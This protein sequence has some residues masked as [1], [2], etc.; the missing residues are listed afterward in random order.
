MRPMRDNYALTPDG[1]A[2]R[3]TAAGRVIAGR[4]IEQ[5]VIILDGPELGVERCYDPHNLRL[6]AVSG[7]HEED[8]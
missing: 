6:M 4:C 1:W 3:L 5:W 2:C 8:V 7:R